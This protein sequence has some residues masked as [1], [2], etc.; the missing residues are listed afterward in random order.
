M[1]DIIAVY[2]I[3]YETLLSQWSLLFSFFFTHLLLD[4]LLLYYIFC[5]VI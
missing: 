2:M 1:P 4:V 3:I 5:P